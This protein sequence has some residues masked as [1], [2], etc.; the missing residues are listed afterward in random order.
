M[1]ERGDCVIIPKQ[2]SRAPKAAVIILHW[3]NVAG[4][5]LS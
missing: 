4:R 1:S 5:E 3:C 2:S